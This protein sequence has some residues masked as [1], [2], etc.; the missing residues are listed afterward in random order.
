MGKTDRTRSPRPCDKCGA[1]SSVLYRL[2]TELDGEWWFGCK[3]CQVQAKAN[4]PDYQYGGTW[5]Q[6]KRH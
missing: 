1:L 5:K 2:L 6:K 4:Y 3:S